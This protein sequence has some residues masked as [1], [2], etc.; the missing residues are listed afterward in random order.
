MRR[1]LVISK[2]SREVLG[3]RVGRK[4]SREKNRLDLLRFYS[5]NR[6]RTKTNSIT[7]CA[8]PQLLGALKTML[9]EKAYSILSRAGK[10]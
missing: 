7:L 5:Y 10:S 6:E 8:A 2:I 4:K 3:S 1:A 9:Y